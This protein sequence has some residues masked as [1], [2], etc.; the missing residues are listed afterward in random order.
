MVLEL[1]DQFLG[2]DSWPPYTS[3]N[4]GSSPPGHRLA[5]SI[6][7]NRFLGFIK[8]LK[9]LPLFVFPFL[10]VLVKKIQEFCKNFLQ[11]MHA[12][13]RSYNRSHSFTG[14]LT[15]STTI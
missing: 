11:C 1:A 10:K 13:S 5:V 3:T 6:P 8:Y 15:A 4:M 7:W 12:L 2:I 14:T 9:I